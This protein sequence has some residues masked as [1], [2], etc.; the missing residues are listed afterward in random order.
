MTTRKP[1]L[2]LLYVSATETPWLQLAV[3]TPDSAASTKHARHWQAGRATSPAQR[4]MLPAS[5][6]TIH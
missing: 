4:A 1:K 6:R 3:A 2:N 5:A